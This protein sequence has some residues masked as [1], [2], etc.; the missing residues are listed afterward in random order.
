MAEPTGER[1]DDP[2]GERVNDSTGERVAGPSSERLAEPAGER[3]NEPSGASADATAADVRAARVIRRSAWLATAAMVAV[4]LPG[5]DLAAT[6]AVWAGMIRR[7]AHCYGENPSRE[8][9]LRLAS[10]LLRGVVLTLF[11]WFGSAK[12]ATLVLKLVPFAGTVTA[13]FVDAGIAAFGARRITAA[14][15]TAAAAYYKSGKT[16]A[17]NT[18]SEHVARVAKDPELVAE[19]LGLIALQRAARVIKPGGSTA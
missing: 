7:V 11:A 12:T 4:P 15:G 6:F 1:T 16:L 2:T 5:A 17:P 14:L 19:V 13:Y 8:D 3:V 18:L 9:A 10:E